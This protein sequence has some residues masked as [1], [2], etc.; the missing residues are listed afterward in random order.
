MTDNQKEMI[1]LALRGTQIGAIIAC[2]LGVLREDLPRFTSKA[3]ITSDG[4]VQA[5]FVDRDGVTRH[6]AFVGSYDDLKGNLRNAL[7][8]LKANHDLTDDEAS[9]VFNAVAFDWIATDY[10]S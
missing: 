9:V 3:V 10:R 7:E 2:A 8:Y 6:S 1:A 5:N 4:F